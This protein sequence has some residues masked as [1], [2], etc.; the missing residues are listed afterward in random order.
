MLDGCEHT[1]ASTNLRAKSS[2]DI[3]PETLY[4]WLK[5]AS[6]KY[7]QILRMKSTLQRLC[8]QSKFFTVSIGAGVMALAS[9]VAI[10]FWPVPLTAQTLAV[11]LLALWLSPAATF[12]SVLTWITLGI[13]GLPVFSCFSSGLGVLL[14][15][16]G[17]YILGML[18]ISAL[19]AFCFERLKKLS[20]WTRFSAFYGISALGYA[21]VL[22]CGWMQLSFLLDSY[23][24][25][26][27]LGVAPFLLGELFLKPIIVACIA[28]R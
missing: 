4:K 5:Y 14:S 12:T 21:I 19:S 28:R 27:Y 24:R 22:S 2:V 8:G 26:W 18:L 25:A 3:L 15:T 13:L 17:G 1:A 6:E 16:R 20:G 10:P 9:Q 7:M 11:S 23:E